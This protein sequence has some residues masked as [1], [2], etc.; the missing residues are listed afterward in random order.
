MWRDE[1]VVTE[2]RTHTHSRQVGPQAIG[3][4]S[5]DPCHRPR[6]EGWQCCWRQSGRLSPGK[7]VVTSY[8]P[9]LERSVSPTRTALTLSRSGPEP[10]VLFQVHITLSTHE[11]AGLSERDINL[12][13]FIEQV[14]VSMT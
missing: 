14:A 7:S 1:K 13:S 9:G 12:A 2:R 3:G 10:L 4:R 11:C 8:H 5:C 6:R